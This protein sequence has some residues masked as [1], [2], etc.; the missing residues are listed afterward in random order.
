MKRTFRKNDILLIVGLLAV[1]GVLALLL[2]VNRQ[3]G[4]MVVVRYGSEIR[5]QY[6]ISETLTV[7]IE[8]GQGGKNTVHI[9]K[10]VVWMEEANCPDHL[11]VQQGKI[12]YAG[13]SIICLPNAV[14]VEIA[15]EDELALDGVVN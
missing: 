12:R 15:G 4:R 3:D 14:V 10:G 13:E 2:M 6:S 8:N 11:C 9:Q 1:S 5:G 7:P